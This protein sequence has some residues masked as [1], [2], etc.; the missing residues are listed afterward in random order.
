MS[1]AHAHEEFNKTF[2]QIQ[3][4]LSKFCELRPQ[5][6]KLF[7]EEIQY[8]FK[9][10]YCENAKFLF[11]AIAPFI[12]DFRNSLD[13][14]MFKFCCDKEN[15]PCISGECPI[16]RDHKDTLIG[17][18]Q[19]DCM[20]KVV[21]YQEWRKNGGYTEKI[22]E[23]AA[24]VRDVVEK[25]ISGLKR[26]KMHIYLKKIQQQFFYDIK[27]TQSPK[28]ATMVVDFAENY[29]VKGQNEV[30]SSYFGRKQISVFTCVSWIGQEQH[31]SFAIINDN[32]QHSKEQVYFYLK[33]I[34]SELQKEYDLENLVIFSDGASSQFKNRF[35]L[36]TVMFSKRD[37]NLDMEWHFFC[38]SHGK[39]SAD[40]IGAVVKRGVYQRVLLDK[41]S[42]YTAK[43]FVE[44][45]KTFCNKIN[46]FEVKQDDVIEQTRAIKERWNHI[47]RIDGSRDAHCFKPSLLFG[48]IICAKSS[49]MDDPVEIGIFN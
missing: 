2:P 7:T 44:C 11:N 13:D 23:H 42:V 31:E 43:K 34:I 29:S 19:V 18:L 33:L 45:C 37:F 39:S 35:S 20:D 21:T 1:L 36:S 48:S 25:I 4:S 38:T 32:I 26:L 47:S 41:C 15:Y 8:S 40:G 22:T 24:T 17:I 28:S 16:C 49:L 9:C 27:H 5:N 14:V 30:Q 46:V 6:V 12:A 10:V 3:I